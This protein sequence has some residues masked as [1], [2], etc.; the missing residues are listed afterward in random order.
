MWQGEKL[1]KMAKDLGIDYENSSSEQEV[2]ESI[3]NKVG[4]EDYNNLYDKDKLEEK[5]NYYLNNRDDWDKYNNEYNKN[6]KRN[7]IQ[8]PSNRNSMLS[9]TLKKSTTQNL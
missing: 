3:A 8:M 2:I 7:A 5:L 9:N 1:K 6:N 4:M